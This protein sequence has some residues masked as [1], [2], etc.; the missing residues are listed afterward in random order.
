MAANI[1]ISNTFATQAGPIPL[2]QLDTNYS[3]LVTAFNTLGNFA[4]YYAD[5]S[6]SANALVVTVS[7]P[8]LVSY[9]AGLTLFV[10]VAN[11]NTGAS[12]ISVNALGAKSITTPSIGALSAGDLIAGAVVQLT[13]DGTQFQLGAVGSFTAL[14]ATTLAVSGATTLSSNVTIA[15]PASGTALT[16]SAVSGGEAI[17]A[18]DGTVSARIAG[19]ASSTLNIGTTSAHSVFISTNGVQRFGANSSG[20]V[21]INAPSSGVA[22]T[23]TGAAG[24]STLAVSDTL[25]PKISLQV[26]GTQRLA[27]AYTNATTTARL[28]SDG[29]LD[30]AS[31]N[32]AR[33]NL[34]TTGNVTINAPSSGT[35]LKVN[36][37]AEL[38]Y[39]NS[40]AARGGGNNYQSWYDP[41]GRKGYIGY[42]SVVDD[43]F[44]L[45]NEMNSQMVL[46]TNATTRVSIA[47]AGNVTIA[48]PSSGYA[49]QVTG[50]N[51]TSAINVIGASSTGAVIRMVD[52]QT[53]NRVWQTGVG[54]GSAGYFG[55]YDETAAALRVSVDTSGNL[56][57]GTTNPDARLGVRGS[58][59]S[60][61]VVSSI[62]TVTGDTAV[63]HQQIIKYDNNSTTSQVFTKFYINQGAVACGQINANGANNAAFGATSDRRVK[64][65][66]VDLGPQLQN[67]MSL[68]P[69]EFDYIDSYGGGHQIGFIAQEHQAIY[70][71][72]VCADTSE[73]KILSLT[74]WSKTEAR[75]V[76]AMQE[77]QHII[78]SLS[79]RLNALELT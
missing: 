16:I 30:L 61:P 6:G 22:L 52:G 60:V 24:A 66:I 14:R 35:A 55:I 59:A 21:S 70:P 67:I 27:L 72:T 37:L 13:Y 65:N 64:T 47:S 2:S 51:A 63:P 23:V 68:R 17:T 73:E 33:V 36:G 8:Q 38:Q 76:K 42:G 29:S 20:N 54:F 50:Y 45:A 10:K 28:D 71:D 57:I 49:L 44:F 15:A 56:L 62:G 79:S 74:G 25:I 31:N 75:L 3:Q 78:D 34:A 41:T 39:W 26:S 46:Q 9:A 58:G 18:T 1:T 11:T 5:S 4:N 69:V 77:Q 7:S 32:T 19:F 12:T 48:A 43:T 40:T 53:G